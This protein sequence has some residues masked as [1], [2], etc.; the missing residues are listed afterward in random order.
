MTKNK[1]LN[2]IVD[3]EIEKCRFGKS[4]IDNPVEITINNMG[5]SINSEFSDHSPVV[6]ADESVLIFTS[7]RENDY[8]SEISSDPR[9][10]AS[11]QS[12]PSFLCET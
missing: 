10:F 2:S 5:D 1:K 9:F 6:S 8:G 7:R 11:D 3:S 4:F 12:P